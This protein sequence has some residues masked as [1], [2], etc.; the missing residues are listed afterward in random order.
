[1]TTYFGPRTAWAGV[2]VDDTADNEPVEQHSQ[3][4]QVLFDGRRRHLGFQVLD[5]SGDVERLDARKLI[6]VLQPHQA[7]KRRVAF[8]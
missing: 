4:G 3:R 2:D 6:D 8:N 7:A 5:E 1:L